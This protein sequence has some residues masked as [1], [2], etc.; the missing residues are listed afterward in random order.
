MSSV[1][2][3]VPAQHS[4][5]LS[6]LTESLP[7]LSSPTT[8]CCAYSSAFMSV[9]TFPLER[10]GQVAR[11]V[12]FPDNHFRLFVILNLYSSSRQTWPSPWQ[13][14]HEFGHRSPSGWSGLQVSQ[15]GRLLLLPSSTSLAAT[16]ADP[17]FYQVPSQCV[18]WP[19]ILAGIL[20]A[21]PSSQWASCSWNPLPLSD[22]R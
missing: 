13:P 22:V 20:S 7:R 10:P 1:V 17:T 16:P 14:S 19:Y 6:P 9:T 3:H 8:A 18:C 11:G 15:Q 12:W 2:R 4:F 5:T 21:N